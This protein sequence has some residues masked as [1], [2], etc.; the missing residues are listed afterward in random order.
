MAAAS[1]ADPRTHLPEAACAVE[2]AAGVATAQAQHA[3]FAGY[4]ASAEA[5]SFIS[6]ATGLGAALAAFAP[7]QRCCTH[8]HVPPPSAALRR[9]VLGSGSCAAPLPD[10]LLPCALEVLRVGG[11]IVRR[12]L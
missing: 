7:H 4:D 5:A 8:R 3:L 9:L 1:F 11:S 10:S 6:A 12:S 2:A